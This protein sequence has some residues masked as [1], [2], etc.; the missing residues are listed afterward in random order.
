MPVR[1]SAGGAVHRGAVVERRLRAQH[2]QATVFTIVVFF[3]LLLL[4]ATSINIGQAVTRRIMLQVVADAGAFT[5]ATEMARG[6][7]TLA[8][9]NHRIQEDWG[10]LTTATLGFSEPP[11]AAALPAIASYRVSYLYW[12][13][14]FRGANA[15]Y[16]QRAAAEARRVTAANAAQLFP[17]ESGPITRRAGEVDAALRVQRQHPAA[18]LVTAR[19]VPNFTRVAPDVA[20]RSP[21]RRIVQFSCLQP[22]LP[23]LPVQA[24]FSL[25]YEKLP[26]PIVGFAWVVKAPAR[27]ARLFDRFFSAGLGRPTIPEMTAVAWA[28]PVGGEIRR[29][30]QLYRAKL[31][32]LR[33]LTPPLLQAVN[34]A[35][36][37]TEA[38]RH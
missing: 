19:E 32:P 35:L 10:R 26:R 28:K 4:A 22:P 34:P 1:E 18:R 12:D 37:R 24:T 20:A 3:T 11:C 38:V 14:V 6:L 30:R 21:G 2:G 33:A 13:S 17:G 23:P 29:G 36:R 5:G 16:S 31:M 25:W 7:N 8:R 15:L 9:I 27:A